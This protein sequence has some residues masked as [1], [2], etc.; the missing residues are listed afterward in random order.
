MDDVSKLHQCELTRSNKEAE[1]MQ[2]IEIRF[3][4]RS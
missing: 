2:R 3:E 4:K 1:Q